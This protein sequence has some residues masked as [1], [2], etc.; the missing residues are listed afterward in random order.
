MALAKDNRLSLYYLFEESVH[1]KLDKDC[2]WSREGLFTW[3]Q[4]YE[5]VN[6]FGNWF[7]SQGIQPNEL[8]AFC[9]TNTPDLL[10]AWLGLWSIGAAPAMINHN[11]T[12]NALLHSL[13]LSKAKILIVDRDEDVRLRI[14]QSKEQITGELGMK[15]VSLS[16]ELRQEI[17]NFEAKRPDDLY[18]S[19][20]K[21]E[22]PVAMFYTSSGTT[23]FPKAVLFKTYRTYLIINRFVEPEDRW[24]VCMP[25]YHATGAVVAFSALTNGNTLA[26]G[27]K[28]STSKFWREIHDSQSTWLCYVG[29]IA[30]YLLAAPPSPL[31]TTHKIKG[32]FGNGL[33]PDVWIKFRDRFQ[34]ETIFEFFSSSEGV[35]SLVNVCKGDYLAKAVGHH[36]ALA[37]FAT[38]NTIVPVMVDDVTGEILRDAKTGFAIR[39]PYH[40]GGEIIV[41]VN[42]TEEFAG[43]HGDRNATEK[44]FARNAFQKGDLWYR[45]GDSLKRTPDGRWFFLDRLGD[46]FRWKGEN[47]ST[48]E[49]AEV[50]GQYPGIIEANVF[51]VSI[52]NHDGKVGCAAIYI[53]PALKQNFDFADFLRHTRSLLPPYAVPVF[54]RL[55]KEVTLT[56]NFKQN[57]VSLKAEGIDPAKVQNSDE[58]LWI[59]NNGRGSNFQKFLQ[60]DWLMIQ[61]NK[62]RL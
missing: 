56:H 44:K 54:L 40:I 62:V 34:I 46:T 10:F 49:V 48:A 15:I 45:S 51:G 52:P 6:Q 25:L 61:K 50:L 9:L 59:E 22:S 16:D 12:G 55:L 4:A 38:R 24:Y 5:K 57:K 30:R 32:M 58:F 8:V 36:G 37:R 28:F 7:L 27:K 13:K 31:D 29:E 35:L 19:V 42:N 14:K 17:Y 20:V 26:I 43:Y 2:I 3:S 41:K 33:R 1:Q 60:N 18:R 53:D 47:V 11:L 39:Q 23:G 21:D